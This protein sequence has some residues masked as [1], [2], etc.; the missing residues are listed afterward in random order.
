MQKRAMG[1][2]SPHNPD[3]SDTVLRATGKRSP[4]TRARTPEVGRRGWIGPTLHCQHPS[5]C[6]ASEALPAHTQ[7]L[8]SEI[9]HRA[10]QARIEDTDP[11]LNG[12]GWDP[13]YQA[14]I[15]VAPSLAAPSHSEDLL[16]FARE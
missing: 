8:A 5:F 12:C 7:P 16:F 4:G 1:I 10:T 15:G 11:N 6:T 9:L 14:E 2:T 13:E 3:L